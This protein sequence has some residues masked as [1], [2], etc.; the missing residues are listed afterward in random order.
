L[1]VSKGSVAEE[2]STKA[3]ELVDKY[4]AE[5]TLSGVPYQPSTGGSLMQRYGP[6]YTV[7]RVDLR[8]IERVEFAVLL[9][10]LPLYLDG[11]AIS[12]LL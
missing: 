10:E 7:V 2:G 9:Q 6:R 1:E 11:L 4:R 8:D 12:L 3:V 5:L